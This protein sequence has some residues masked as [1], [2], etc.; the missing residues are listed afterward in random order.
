MIDFDKDLKN[1]TLA[2]LR[3]LTDELDQKRYIADYIFSFI[4]EKNVTAID[5]ITPLSKAFRNQLTDDGFYISSLAVE[6]KLIDPDGTIKYLFRLPD[7]KS[8]ETVLLSDKDRRTLCVS[9]QV[10]C[11]MGCGFCATGKIK[12]QRD[13][14]A[15]EIADQVYALYR[16]KQKINNVVFM[17][18]GEPLLNYDNTLK[19]VRILNHSNGRN[20]GIRHLTVSTCGIVPAIYQLAGEDIIPRLAVSLNASDDRLRSKIMPINKKY[21]LKELLSALADYQ[22]QT[23]DRVT[24]EYVLIKNINDSVINA[25]KLIRFVKPVKCNVNLIEFNPH[26]GCIYQASS[27]N[28]INKFAAVLKEAGIETTIRMKQGQEIKAACGQLGADRI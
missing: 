27:K 12:L 5:D 4:H 24:F 20:I 28:A 1:K 10:G 23:K 11:A 18:M 3:A 22:R 14:S 19:A 13:M 17:G 25:K 8:I 21:P 16:D 26:P 15:A 2:E 7:G 6:D 9:T